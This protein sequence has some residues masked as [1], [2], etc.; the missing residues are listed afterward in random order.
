MTEPAYQAIKFQMDET[1][2]SDYVLFP[3][4]S[5]RATKPHIGSLKKATDQPTA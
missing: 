3:T 2:D 1:P 4:L 5:L